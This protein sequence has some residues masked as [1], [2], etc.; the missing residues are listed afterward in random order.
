TAA[1]T[2]IAQVIR[3]LL[4]A[5]NA[6]L[7]RPCIRGEF[8]TEAN[9]HRVLQVRPSRLD[10]VIELLCLRGERGAQRCERGNERVEL[11]EACQPDRG[12]DRVVRALRHVYL[13][14]GVYGLVLT[15]FSP[16]ELVRAI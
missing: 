14:V 11:R 1:D 2:E 5:T 16:E 6:T 15:T 9:R 8:L 12:G 3:R 7:D 13:I 10:D 4:D